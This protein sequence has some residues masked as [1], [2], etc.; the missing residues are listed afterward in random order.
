M[1]YGYILFL[2]LMAHAV[3]DFALQSDWMAKAKA[4]IVQ[5]AGL[6]WWY[7]M[8]MHCL[9]NAAGVYAVAAYV[10][11][12]APLCAMLAALE[13]IAHFATDA[14]KRRLYISAISDQAFHVVAKAA[15]AWVCVVGVEGAA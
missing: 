13:Y 12:S 5:S 4:S 7:V 6:P 1:Q 10:G 8:A 11:V 2:M 15:W 3:C 14:T 9:I